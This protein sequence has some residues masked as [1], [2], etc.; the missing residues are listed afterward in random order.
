[1]VE[2][3]INEEDRRDADQCEEEPTNSHIGGGIYS[4]KI[5]DGN[6]VKDDC[7]EKIEDEKKDNQ[8]RQEHNI[9]GGNQSGE[10]LN[11]GEYLIK[12]KYSNE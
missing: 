9:M 2:G 12:E 4:D 3:K 1:M 8:A 11:E 6:K 5:E 7:G 10:G